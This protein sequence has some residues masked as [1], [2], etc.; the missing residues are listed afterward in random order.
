MP[1]WRADAE[2]SLP[3]VYNKGDTRRCEVSTR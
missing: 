1:N 3:D 2:I